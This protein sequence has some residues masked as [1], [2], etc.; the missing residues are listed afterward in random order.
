MI[1]SPQ[2][3]QLVADILQAQQAGAC[4][5]SACEE[6]GISLRTFERWQQTGQV[7]ADARPHA[8]R[9]EPG[10]KLTPEERQQILTLC[11]ESPFADLPPAQIVPQ[12]AYESAYKFGRGT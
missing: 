1:A 3:Q 5:E 6:L 9:P 8:K 12:L 2:R 7:Q 11:H 4:L 10:R